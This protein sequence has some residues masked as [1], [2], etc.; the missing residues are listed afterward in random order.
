MRNRPVFRA[1]A[2]RLQRGAVA[3]EFALVAALFLLTLLLGIIEL[4]RAF[5]YMNATAEATR[6]GA[7]IAVVCEKGTT[8]GYIRARMREFVSVLP[9][10]SI[11]I[12]WEPANCTAD[13]PTV[14][15]SVT[16]SVLPGATFDTF[17][18]FVPLTWNLP[19][20][21]TTLPRESMRSAIEG[22][23]NPVCN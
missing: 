23:P 16:V 10:A 11:A 18:P 12:Q 3:V 2:Q 13:G 22:V 5:F 7:R 6:L 4:G 9:D 19:P 8:D 15:R 1:V 14:C 17:I 20:F 21:A